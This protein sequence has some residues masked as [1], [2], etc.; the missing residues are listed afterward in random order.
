MGLKLKLLVLLTSIVLLAACTSTPAPTPTATQSPTPTTT[1]A[2][3]PTTAPPATGNL[4]FH[5]ID[6]GQGD[7]ILVQFPNGKTMLVDGGDIGRGDE[8]VAYLRSAGVS[9]LDVVVATHTDAD[10]IGGLPEVF[11]AFEVDLYVHNGMSHTTQAFADLQA[12]VQAEGSRLIT[13][14]VGEQLQIDPSVIV[15]VRAPP[16][17]LITGSRS[18]RNANSVVLLLDYSDV[19]ILLTGDPEEETERFLERQPVDIDILKVGHHGSKYASSD[20]F[21]SAFSPE[22]G[23]ISAG[24]TNRYDHP[25]AEALQ[26]LAAHGVVVYCTCWGKEIIVTT[27]GVN[28]AVVRGTSRAAQAPAPAPTPQPTP[29]QT[30]APAPIVSGNCDPSYPTV[31]IPPPPPDLDCKNV[32]YRRFKVLPPDPHKFDTDKDGIGCE[33]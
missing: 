27:D 33:S 3:A 32:T 21:L 30:P 16:D 22:L 17:P 9:K 15:L 7:S 29:T 13:A 19:E 6:I 11:R 2:P 24:D 23:L 31:C 1:A 20:A 25:H 18:D 5:V 14:S 8:V 26:R 28:Y 12:A 4:T 10:H